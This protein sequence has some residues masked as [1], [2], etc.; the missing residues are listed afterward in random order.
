MLL[1]N[2]ESENKA[3]CVNIKREVLDP[4]DDS[5]VSVDHQRCMPSSLATAAYRQLVPDA[6]SKPAASAATYFNGVSQS[7]T[8][9]NTPRPHAGVSRL[10]AFTEHG[11]VAYM[12]IDF[13]MGVFHRGFQHLQQLLKFNSSIRATI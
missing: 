6:L 5:T 10:L 11:T 4:T 3:F 12:I 1:S 7:Q 9:T 13:F 2:P 8:S